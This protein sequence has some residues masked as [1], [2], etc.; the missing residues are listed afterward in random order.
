MSDQIKARSDAVL[1]TLPE[2]RQREVADFARAHSLAATVAWLKGE[3][4]RSSSGALSR[5]LSWWSVRQQL[6]RNESVVEA[7]LEDLAR[8]KP[9]MT[10]DQLTAAGQRFFSA[11][12]LEQAN[13]GNWARIQ[14]LSL[15]RQANELEAR[16]V[17]LLEDRAKLAQQAED[18]AK[19]ALTD[20]QKMARMREIFGLPG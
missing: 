4:I 12:A 2:E 7:M 6:R 13:A 1:K 5:F 18:V 15:A 8:E 19:S 9:E 11:L 20:A 14:K 16:R 3:G 17:K 10:E